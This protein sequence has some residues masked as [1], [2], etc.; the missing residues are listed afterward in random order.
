MN[1]LELL[2]K[3]VEELESLVKALLNGDDRAINLTGVPIGSVTLGN[4]CQVTM[5]N[6]PTG[7]VFHGDHDSL[8]EAETRLDELTVQAEELGALIDDLETRLDDLRDDLDQ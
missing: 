7:T 4:G 1:E 3:R 8:E 6:C 2:K 5:N